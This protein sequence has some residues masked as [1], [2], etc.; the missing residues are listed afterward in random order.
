MEN[1]HFQWENS[2]FLWSF[3][4]A[5]LTSPEGTPN[6]WW[7]S[8]DFRSIQRG[9]TWMVQAALRGKLRKAMRPCPWSRRAARG[10]MRFKGHMAMENSP[11]HL[12]KTLHDTSCMNCMRYYEIFTYK[13]GRCCCTYQDSFFPAPCFAYGYV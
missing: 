1:H 2:L 13:T 7:I 3:S 6:L 10:T 12:L 9:T 8:S 4:I 11:K 5:I